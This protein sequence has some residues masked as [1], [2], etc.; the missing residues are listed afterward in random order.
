MSTP[1]AYAR[2]AVEGFNGAIDV[3]WGA[4]D[5]VAVEFGPQLLLIVA[6]EVAQDLYERLGAC[7]GEARAR[8]P[9]GS[10]AGR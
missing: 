7:L 4:T 3:H 6:P 1:I 9:A 2:M 5:R 10:K 8:T